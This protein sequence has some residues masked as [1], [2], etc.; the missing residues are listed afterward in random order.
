MSNIV[1]MQSKE[2]GYASPDI[3]EAARQNDPYH[4]SLALEKGQ[5][6]DEQRASDG[7]TPVHEAASFGSI[8]FLKAAVEIAPQTVWMRDGTQRRPIEHACARDDRISIA[9]LSNAMYPETAIC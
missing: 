2:E 4:M 7:M 6:L 1:R 5:K 9:V 8:D 3:F